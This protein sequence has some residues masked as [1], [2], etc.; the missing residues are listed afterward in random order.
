MQVQSENS[1][2]NALG[3]MCMGLSTSFGG[4]NRHRGSAERQECWQVSHIEE[5]ETTPCCTAE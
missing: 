5:C 3:E 2:G 4:E 1:P